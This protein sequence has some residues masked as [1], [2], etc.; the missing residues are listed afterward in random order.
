MNVSTEEIESRSIECNKN[1]FKAHFGPSPRTAAAVWNDLC[2]TNIV[3]AQLSPNEKNEK[4]L[5]CFLMALH[6]IW[7]NPKNR[8][9]L[10]RRFNVSEKQASGEALWK[11]VERIAA[12]ESSVIIW[13]Q[14]TF[15]DN[16]GPRFILT[17]DTKDFKCWEKKHP[18]YNMDRSYASKKNGMHAGFKFE[19][20]LSV[21]TDQIAWING[22]FKATT[23]DLTIFRQGLKQQFH[24]TCS[25]DIRKYIICDRGYQTSKASEQMLAVPSSTDTLPLKKFKSLARCRQEDMNSRFANYK[26]MSDEWTYTV[27]QFNVCFRAVAVLIQYG[28]NTGDNK[29]SIVQI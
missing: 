18:L 19:V 17:V 22:P 23:H 26:M 9:I 8:F 2:S 27:E 3:D 16:N 29:L 7:A 10:K 25:G 20:A 15:S 28:L 13:P 4:G 5:H 6:F 14:E 24:A 11:W 1:E 12:L 21:F